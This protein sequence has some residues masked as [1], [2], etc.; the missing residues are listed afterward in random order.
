MGQK[1]HGIQLA[2]NS[3]ADN[4]HFE[5]L[6]SD[7]LPISPGRIW[8]N[9]T[10]KEF[11]FSSLDTGGG[12]TINSFTTIA[13][14]Q[15]AITEYTNLV[16][17]EVS[18][19]EAAITA[20][21]VA[22]AAAVA[23]LNQAI[24]DEVTARN[25]AIA[26]ETAA[27]VAADAVAASTAADQLATETAARLSGDAALGVR[28]DGVQ[29]ELDATQTAAG[30]NVDGTFTAPLNT[31]YLG[32][33]TSLK[34]ASAK[35]DEGLTSEVATRVGQVAA[36]SSA[37]AN[38]AQSRA[39]GDIALQAQITAYIDSAVTNNTNADNAE[40][41]AR[42]A[43]DAA[44]KAELDLTQATIGT[45]PDGSLIPITGTHYLDAVTTVFGGAFVLDTQV[46]NANTA[47]AAEVAGR[48]AADVTLTNALQT[49]VT[50]RT[51][52]DTALQE[53]MNTLEAGA[54][55]ETDGTYAAPTG[56]NYLGTAISLKD[57]D[58]VLDAALKAV[59]NQVVTLSTTVVDGINTSIANE[60]ARATAAEAAE[61]SRALAAESTITASVT[62][63]VSRATAAENALTSSLAST[64]SALT[65]EVNRATAAEANL[66]TQVN[67]IVA[68]SGEG[69]AALKVEIN[70][71]RYSVTATSAALVHV[72]NHNLNT[73]NYLVNVM[74]EGGDG[75]YRNDICPVEEIDA[76][77]LRV[78]LSEARKVKVSVMDM[79]QLA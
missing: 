31:T 73:A 11:K 19:R 28:I 38:E 40:T 41:V 4:F 60:V 9:T 34:D 57:A 32:T 68:A 30:L 29:A 56:S 25:A 45:A 43:A 53:E 79:S 67:A 62:A 33:A 17:A 5:R 51:A 22:R 8:F 61:N 24:S 10:A 14:L 44:I 77:S 66:Q 27:R 23:S 70:S 76:N 55:L 18:A 59:S 71:G 13:A 52:A 15:A 69:A 7:P 49:E 12:V 39:D 21:Q 6:A 78:T 42:I 64:N 50:N 1:F 65:S 72:I 37:I 75:V 26:A 58:Y 2:A 63:E 47:I 20:E 54:G 48:T 35:L 3:T 74:V 46:F 16:A 36:L